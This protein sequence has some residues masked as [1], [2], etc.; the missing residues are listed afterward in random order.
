ML[1]ARKEAWDEAER[2]ALKEDE[3]NR[4]TTRRQ[5]L[6]RSRPIPT[7]RWLDNCSVGYTTYRSS[8]S[9]QETMIRTLPAETL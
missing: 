2:K 4:R 1:E 6:G 7:K 9:T 8:A 5:I 3:S